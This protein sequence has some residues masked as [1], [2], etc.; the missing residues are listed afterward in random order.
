LC[1]R[2]GLDP[3]GVD[4]L[5]ALVNASGRP[6][7][8]LP[9]LEE[10][11]AGVVDT[12]PLTWLTRLVSA[13]E[14]PALRNRLRVDFSVVDNIKY[15]NGLV[16]KGFVEGVPAGVLSGGQYDNLLAR[17][18][19]ASGA[20][21]FA[22][23]LDRLEQL[24]ALP[25]YDVDAVLLYDEGEDLSLLSRAVEALTSDGSRVMAQRCLPTGVRYARLLRLEKGQVKTVEQDA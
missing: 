9:A 7:E 15:Y 14:D 12:A 13:V 10:K 22:V 19:R 18:G 21:G 6:E 11:L 25:A 23:Y 8:V 17:M 4:C 2:A 3:A 20:V 1:Q 24:D 5:T 16:F